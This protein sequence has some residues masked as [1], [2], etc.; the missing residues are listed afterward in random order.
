MRSS[1]R[2]RTG[3]LRGLPHKQRNDAEQSLIQADD[4]I[5]SLTRQLERSRGDLT[6]S[7]VQ[8]VVSKQAEL[9]HQ[10]AMS[11]KPVLSDRPLLLDQTFVTEHHTEHRCDPFEAAPAAD[12]TEY[13]QTLITDVAVLRSKPARAPVRSVLETTREIRPKTG[14]STR[15]LALDRHGR[16]TDSTHQ[17]TLSQSTDNTRRPNTAGAPTRPTHLAHQTG[18][19]RQ[20]VD[21]GTS[22]CVVGSGS[23][24]HRPSTLPSSNLGSYWTTGRPK[25]QRPPPK[26]RDQTPEKPRGERH[27]QVY[28]ALLSSGDWPSICRAS[29]GDRPTVPHSASK[30]ARVSNKNTRRGAKSAPHQRRSQQI[31]QQ[32][33]DERPKGPERAKTPVERPGDPY[34]QQQQQQQ[35]REHQRQQQQQQLLQQQQL[36]STFER[37][38]GLVHQ[39]TQNSSARRTPN[40]PS[41]R[42][43]SVNT[44][45]SRRPSV[46]TP[47]SARHVANTPSLGRKALRKPDSKASSAEAEFDKDFARRQRNER[48]AAIGSV[49][50]QKRRASHVA[51]RFEERLWHDG[52]HYYFNPS[53]GKHQW[54]TPPEDSY[55]PC[56]SYW[57]QRF[58][59]KSH[60][61]YYLNWQSKAVCWTVPLDGFEH[62]WQEQ[63]DKR[64]GRTYYLNC[65]TKEKQSSSPDNTAESGPGFRPLV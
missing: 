2:S 1:R 29:R 47:S 42:Q 40:T 56:K 38:S 27:C 31:E 45:S 7:N 39:N 33:S 21:A 16:L 51:D 49:K 65:L 55:T 37:V 18:P 59:P 54:Q 25:K 58:D 61:Y 11:T 64:T 12:V 30:S 52:R 13:S 32:S 17:A 26:I 23:L 8:P 15:S 4:L 57:L 28:E 19:R 3:D 48:A 53:S 35:Q 50:E 20:S 41:S 62:I 44:P 9:R 22:G 60:R 43:P 34:V 14:S 46:N 24:G 63:R 6:A 36:Q 10:S 5:K